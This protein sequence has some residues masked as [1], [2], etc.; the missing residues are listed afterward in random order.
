MFMA[1]ES[2]VGVLFNGVAAAIIIGK[3]ARVQSIAQVRFSH[4]ICIR[5]GAAVMEHTTAPPGPG[6]DEDGPAADGS[7]GWPCPIFE[8]RIINMMS[9]ERGN[10]ILNATVSVVA[11]ILDNDDESDKVRH[12]LEVRESQSKLALI[13][14]TTSAV[15][16]VGSVGTMAVVAGTKVAKNTGTALFSAGKLATQTTGSL[17]QQLNRQLQW[18]PRDNDG[19][20]EVIANSDLDMSEEFTVEGTQSLEARVLETLERNTIQGDLTNNKA[21]LSV[22]VD[23]GNAHL[24]PPRTYHKLTVCSVAC[25]SFESCLIG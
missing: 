14:A 11:S 19:F 22:C 23:E 16:Q 10:A 12:L 13:A 2:F 18:H 25:Y 21:S 8:F 1:F 24:A 5:Y 20:G 9:G 7:R 17:I 6:E 3:I 15:R 4:P